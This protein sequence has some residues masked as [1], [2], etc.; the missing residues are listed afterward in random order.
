MTVFVGLRENDV[1]VLGPLVQGFCSVCSIPARIQVA[2]RR[3]RHPRKGPL[4]IRVGGGRE[5]E[6]HRIDALEQPPK[7][8]AIGSRDAEV[9]VEER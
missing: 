2:Q 1:A 8:A 7:E 4:A 6:T 3:Q 9:L 5:R